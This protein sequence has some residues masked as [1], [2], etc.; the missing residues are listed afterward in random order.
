MLMS[1]TAKWLLVLSVSC[2]TFV[3]IGA[4]EA[5][6]PRRPGSQ[7]TQG[8]TALNEPAIESPIADPITPVA[9]GPANDYVDVVK[10]ELIRH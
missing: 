5:D 8:R 1:Y 7:A 6:E 10:E 9:E 2:V 3:Q 4:V